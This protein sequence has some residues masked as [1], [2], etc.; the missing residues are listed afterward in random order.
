MYPSGELNRLARRKAALHHR[1]AGTRLRC[2]AAAGGV[3]RPIDWLDRLMVQWRR[4][5]PVAKLAAVPLGLLL[6]SR[7]GPRRR[8][9][10]SLLGRAFRFVPVALSVARILA[11]RR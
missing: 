4:I 10:T 11:A 2:A 1:I 6:R 8:G 3:A 7:F 9:G 5:S